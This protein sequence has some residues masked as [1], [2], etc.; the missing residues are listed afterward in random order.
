MNDDG[1]DDAALESGSTN[2]TTRLDTNAL[3]FFPSIYETPGY[4]IEKENDD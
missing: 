4:V 1:G 3:D 2:F